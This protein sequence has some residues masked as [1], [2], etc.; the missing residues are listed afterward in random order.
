MLKLVARISTSNLELLIGKIV[1]FVKSLSTN[2]EIFSFK[3]V[4]ELDIFLDIYLAAKM[5]VMI[6]EKKEII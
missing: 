4:M 5:V 3:S 2:A 1:R 6:K